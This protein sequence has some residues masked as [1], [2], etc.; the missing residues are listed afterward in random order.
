MNNTTEASLILSNNKKE[1]FIENVKKWVVLDS[2]LK[3]VNEKTKK[4]R[5]LKHTMTEDICKYMTENNIKNNNIIISDGKL[6]VYEKKEYTPLTYG[7]IEKCL[8]EIITDKTQVDYV[9]KYLKE[10][11]EI[12]TSYDIRRS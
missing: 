9:I 6:K 7:Y 10:H 11:R 4:L 12:A 1:Q 8:G 5:E 3:I 2:Q